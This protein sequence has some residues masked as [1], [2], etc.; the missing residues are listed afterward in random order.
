MKQFTKLRKLVTV[1]HLY[2]ISLFGESK[3]VNLYKDLNMDHVFINGLVFELEFTLQVDLKKE[4]DYNMTHPIHLIQ[5][6]MQA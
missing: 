4:I 6:L 3:R 2:G 5:S 1:F